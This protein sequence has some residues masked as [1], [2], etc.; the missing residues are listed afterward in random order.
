MPSDFTT[1]DPGCQDREGVLDQCLDES[2]P[3]R[4]L[5]VLIGE[6]PME[7]NVRVQ[8]NCGSSSPCTAL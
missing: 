6:P 1:D 8:T 5:E 3:R 4:A 7:F 2:I